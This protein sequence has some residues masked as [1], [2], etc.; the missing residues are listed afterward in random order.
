MRSGTASA[1]PRLSIVVPV[2]RV[3]D[4]LTECLDSILAYPGDDLEVVAVDDASPDLSG[5]LLD[6]YAGRDPRVTVLHLPANVGLGGARNAGLDRATGRYVWFVD[7]DDWL[8]EGAVAAVTE[9][10]ALTEPD[11][12]IVEHADAFTGGATVRRP[13][14][15]ALARARPPV[16][17]ADCP[18]LLRVVQSSCTKIA[19]RTLL[20]TA[21]LRFRKGWYEDCSFSYPLLLLAR[22]IDVLERLC[23]M[24][25][26]ETGGITNTLSTRHFDVFDQYAYLFEFLDAAGGAYDGFRAELFRAMI[27]HQLVILGHEGRLPPETRRAFFERIVEHYRRWLPL[28]QYAPPGG[29]EGLKHWLVR[30][31]AYP[32]YAALRSTYRVLTGLLPT[33]APD[34]APGGARH[35]LPARPACAQQSH[36]PAGGDRYN[37]DHELPRRAADGRDQIEPTTAAT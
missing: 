4:H 15:L 37:R 14:G 7:S 5:V 1:V 26:Q 36:D 21:G 13:V 20:G 33:A 19:R 34:L 31:S 35:D 16:R 22:T 32:A 3:E 2:Y 27:S 6:G 17:L 28:G 10:L 9:R 8:P 25:R 12:L 23:Y 11:V 18:Q 24:Y 30:T 29:I